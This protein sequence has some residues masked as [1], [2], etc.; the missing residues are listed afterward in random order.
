MNEILKLHDYSKENNSKIATQF[1]HGGKDVIRKLEIAQ[2]IAKEPDVECLNIAAK[3]SIVYAAVR[4]KNTEDEEE[5]VARIYDTN[6]YRNYANVTYIAWRMYE[7]SDYMPKDVYDSTK[8]R[9][10]QLLDDSNTEAYNKLKARL[11]R[12]R[13][14]VLPTGCHSKILKLLTPTAVRNVNQWRTD[15]GD[16]LS[17]LAAEKNQTD[18]LTNLPLLSIIKLN[19]F[20]KDGTQIF[21]VKDKDG[22][23]KYPVWIDDVEGTKY[24]ICDIQKIGY[25]IESREK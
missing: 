21:L 4:T 25:E 11:N 9:L 5:I 14:Y 23:Y 17:A 22:S 7:E 15:C 20:R 13:K 3:N 12:E 19:K 16:I 10:Q 24:K 18:S 6:V 1:C 8:L 2:E